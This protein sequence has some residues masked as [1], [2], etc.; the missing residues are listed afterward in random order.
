[1]IFRPV[2]ILLFSAVCLSAA[3]EKKLPAPSV[4]SAQ[5]AIANDPQRYKD[6]AFF[7]RALAIVRENYVDKDKVSDEK[8][9]KAALS[10]MLRQLDEF[11]TYEDPDR[12]KAIREDTSGQFAGVGM[13]LSRRGPAVEVISVLDGSPAQKAGLLPGDVL[14]EI[15]GKQTAKISFRECISQLKGKPGTPVTLKV[16]RKTAD[17]YRTFSLKREMI[18]I[19]SV[20]GAKILPDSI[21]YLALSGFSLTTEKDLDRALEEFEKKKVKG[22][23]LD[24]RNN[25]GGLL[26]SAIQICSRFLKKGELVVSTEGQTEASKKKFY[27]VDSG[28]YLDVPLVLL[29]N[30][31]SASAAEILA[32]CLQDHNRAVLIGT[33]TFGKGSVQTMIPLPDKGAMRLT[34]AKYYTPSRKVIHGNGI[35][36]DIIVPLTPAAE[37]QLSMQLGSAPGEVVPERKDGVRDIQLERALEVLKGVNLFLKNKKAE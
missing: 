1:M 28:K 3:E 23:I 15:N 21:G 13:T 22:I 2:L 12:F 10:G 17:S 4:P 20:R 34:T 9:L 11:S 18:R 7:L 33:K 8:L 36:P 25:P 30:R 32:G 31:G 35:V 16:Y 37:A 14:T 26:Q 5:E 6:L 27:S 19:S 29:V 24:L